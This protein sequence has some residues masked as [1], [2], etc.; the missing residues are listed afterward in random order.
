MGRQPRQR[1]CGAVLLLP[2][3]AVRVRSDLALRQPELYQ[4]FPGESSAGERGQLIYYC[5]IPRLGRK[6]HSWV[7]V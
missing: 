3:P 5:C 7:Y 6:N 1:F 2:P 4:I